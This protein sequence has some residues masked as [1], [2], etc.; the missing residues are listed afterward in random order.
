MKISLK[1]IASKHYDNI[2]DDIEISVLLASFLHYNDIINDKK[3]Q[4]MY[5]GLRDRSL[6]KHRNVY[7]CNINNKWYSDEPM[8]NILL[9]ILS[10]GYNGVIAEI[11]GK[12]ITK[13]EMDIEIYLKYMNRYLNKN[14]NYCIDYVYDNVVKPFIN[15][16]E[17]GCSFWHFTDHHFHCDNAFIELFGVQLNG[18]NNTK[19]ENF[20]AY[21][22][23][24]EDCDGDYED[25]KRSK[26]E[27]QVL[28]NNVKAIEKGF[29]HIFYWKLRDESYRNNV[30]KF[31]EDWSKYNL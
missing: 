2:L 17:S 27:Y 20:D 10:D 18:F 22:Y 19:L 25:F 13:T 23:C 26:F 9:D 21:G 29:K 30:M 7:H 8:I 31:Q 24:C 5:K 14:R 3:L 28:R 1:L 15:R 12:R 16:Y 4:A 11:S 6:L